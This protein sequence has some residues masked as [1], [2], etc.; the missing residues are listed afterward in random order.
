MTRGWLGSGSGDGESTTAGE[1]VIGEDAPRFDSIDEDVKNGGGEI[2]IS[3][4]S[5]EAWGGAWRGFYSNN[6]WQRQGERSLGWR[7]N[8]EKKGRHG[9]DLILMGGCT[10]VGIVTLSTTDMATWGCFT[11][12]EERREVRRV[13]RTQF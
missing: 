11:T 9:G 6:A 4:G 12:Q 1:D 7:G 13:D 2:V 5:K 10:A 3:D 8:R